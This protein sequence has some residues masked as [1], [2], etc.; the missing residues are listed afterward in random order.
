MTTRPNQTVPAQAPASSDWKFAIR[1]LRHRNY[2]LFFS[3]QTVSLIGTWMTRI[4][5]A[6]L[7]YRLTGSAFL[8]GLVSFSG[9][10][11]MLLLGPFAGVWVDRWNRH[12]VLV[13]T[14]FL[15]MMQSFWLAALA[16]SHRITVTDIILLS[17]FQ[18][19]I[20]SFDMPARQ[21]FVIQM[22]ESR[23]DLP[24]A[25]ALNSSMVNASRL[26]GPSVAGA[27]IAASSE[28]YCF[29]IDGFSYLAVIASLLAMKNFAPQQTGARR[30]VWQE[31][32]EGWRYATGFLP[33]R[34]ILLL[35]A[36]ISLVGMPYSVLMPLFA[37]R[38]L[39]GGPHTL[40]FLM[41]AAGVGALGSAFWLA[42]RKSVLGLGRVIPTMAA[43]FGAALIA[44]SFSRWLWL[45]LLLMVVTGFGMM[46]QM[47]ASNTVLQT[48][49]E[50]DKR[51]RV[52]SFYA[53]S[54]QGMA[55][56]GSLFAGIVAA[57][58]GA[59]FTLAIGGACCIAG[60][61]WF[62]GKLPDIRAHIRP[63]YRKLGVLPEVAVAIQTATA[64]QVPPED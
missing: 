62:V 16:L 38:V 30:R 44:F 41:G 22:V 12:R 31:L 28:G 11:P 5:T 18:G 27:I 43:L 39:H 42:T 19:L 63:I 46:Q 49:V 54:F 58:I 36:L 7:V 17:I 9:Q 52:M 15:S 53:I 51:G 37:G 8:L 25:I 4:A 21:A 2:A 45:S 32:G 60:A 64:L 33:I 10:I 57:R 3:G 14:Q 20:N 35:L 61:L 56:F 59:P 24:N 13:V 48:I 26:I 6:W 47:A 40:G 50:D 23:E 29:L 55:P 1:A 34:S